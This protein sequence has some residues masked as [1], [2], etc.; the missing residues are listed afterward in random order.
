MKDKDTKEK[1]PTAFKG[2]ETLFSDADT[3]DKPT[4]IAPGEKIGDEL[5]TVALAALH[6]FPDHPYTVDATDNDMAELVDSIQRE[7]LLERIVVQR[8]KEGGFE[9][10]SGH[11]RHRACQI[12]GINEVP[13]IIKNGLSKDQAILLMVDANL[14]RKNILPMDEARALKMQMDAMNR[15][16]KRSEHGK[17]KRTDEIIAERID[18]NRMYVQRKVKLLD[19]NA[20]LQKAVN[21]K[22]L[23]ETPAFEIAAL[24]PKVQALFYDW[25]MIED[26]APTV[27][28]AISVRQHQQELTKSG[29]KDA[30]LTDEQLDRIMDGE[31][32]EEIFPLPEPEK[33]ET[34]EKD[35]AASESPS[36]TNQSKDDDAIA[37]A[38]VFAAGAAKMPPDKPGGAEPQPS[39][40]TDAKA[41]PF[42]SPGTSSP[43]TPSSSY[44]VAA[45]APE[46]P[47]SAVDATKA[48]I[49]TEYMAELRKD[50]VI[51]PKADVKD[52]VSYCNTND[53]YV[54]A[55]KAVLAKGQEKKIETKAAENKTAPAK[56]LQGEKDEKPVVPPESPAAKP[57]EPPKPDK[58]AVPSPKAPETPKVDN[59]A[60]A[61][62][63]KPPDAPKVESKAP[64]MPPKAPEAAKAGSAVFIPKNT[65][66]S[67]STEIVKRVEDKIAAAKAGEVDKTPIPSPKSPEP[68]KAEPAKDSGGTKALDDFLKNKARPDKGKG[69]QD[70]IPGKSK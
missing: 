52:Y 59:K 64:I 37:P 13:V 46:K 60:P 28:Q 18:K 30:L 25:M 19:L 58:A 4:A 61:V 38:G 14:K 67:P 20:D 32:L 9:I 27:A 35:S 55:I 62:A 47:V 22:A 16:G 2:V 17:V 24:P 45:P 68:V 23:S 48:Y 69:Q 51:L 43:M 50:N 12:L 15:M 53:E 65:V 31:R 5:A 3:K 44:N 41:I 34:A 10:L 54:A 7:G 49:R 57:T 11:R 56:A 66:S 26:R 29:K 36:A 63:A 40:P 6:A 42:Q 70:K 1:K 21:E 33:V 39:T 8:K